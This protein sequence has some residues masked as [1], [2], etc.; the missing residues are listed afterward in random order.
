MAVNLKKVIGLFRPE[1]S[2]III[3]TC[4]ILLAGV[5]AG[6]LP[7]TYIISLGIILFLY[8]QFLS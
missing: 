5:I 3:T 1:K 7:P 8:V 2:E 4:P 6:N